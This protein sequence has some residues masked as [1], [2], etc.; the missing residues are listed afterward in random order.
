MSK[1]NAKIIDG[2]ISVDDRGTVRFVND[3]DF[4]KIKRFYQ[5]DNFSKH[6]IRAFH[7][8]KKEA[9]YVYV[10]SGSILICL[11]SIKGGKNNVKNNTVERYVLS[12]KKPQILYIP[13]NYANG[14]KALENN[15]SVIF[16][17]TKLLKE[18]AR[19]DIRYPF[20]YWGKEI[21]NTLNC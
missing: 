18:S 14:F 13:E 5:V 6:T 1:Y 20:D 2:G 12:S 11:V 10:S 19:D 15:T 16:Y 7:G 21:W 4:H 17:S 9:K 8:H 3:F